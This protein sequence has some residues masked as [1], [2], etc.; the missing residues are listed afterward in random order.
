MT[1]AARVPSSDE[2]THLLQF[3]ISLRERADQDYIA[4]RALYRMGFLE[5]FLWNANQAIEKY[6]KAILLFNYHTTKELLHDISAA[7]KKVLTIPDIEFDFLPHTEEFISYVNEVGANRYGDMSSKFSSDVLILF[8]QT[9]WYLRRYCQHVRMVW[10]EGGPK[11]VSGFEK[12]IARILDPFW[13]ENPNKFKISGGLF[14][15][16]SFPV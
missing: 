10:N 9:T 2:R 8:D 1:S 12:Q 3:A 15:E 11:E 7:F 14:C 16:A 4:A 6:L 13:K 5:P